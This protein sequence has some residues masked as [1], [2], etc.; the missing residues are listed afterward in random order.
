MKKI[1]IPI[2]YLLVIALTVV[3]TLALSTDKLDQL[4]SLLL[5]RFVDGADRDAL[6]D[7]AAEAMVGALGDR[8]SYYLTADELDSYY[9]RV[10]NSYVG[11]GVTTTLESGVG[12]RI[13]KIENDSPAEKAL[14]QV[15][16]LII[17]VDGRDLADL[18]MTQ[19]TDLIRGKENTVVEMT[20]LRDDRQLSVS[21]TRARVKTAVATATMLDGNVGLVTIEN[22]N[23]N[24]YSETWAAID[25]LLDGGAQ[26]LIFDVRYNGGG[27]VSELLKVLDDLLP[28]GEL[29]HSHYYN[30]KEQTYTSNAKCLE[31]PMAVLIN[32]ESYSAAEFFAA[33]LREYDWAILVGEQTQGKGHFQQLYELKDGSA[34]GLSIGRYTTPNGV[35]LEGVG[36]TPDVTVAVT[37]DISQKIYAGTLDPMADPQILAAIEALQAQKNLD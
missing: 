34:V 13:T 16:D 19:M 17:A 26:A 15:D 28:E 33:A 4:E 11:I 9:D 2:S 30:G 37:E 23:E 22:F 32:S 24:C 20:V 31:M 1:L 7:A 18:S 3:C 8:W 29:F 5:N 6:E 10:K 14:L 35:D 36:L 25:S 21:V 12:L 27:Y